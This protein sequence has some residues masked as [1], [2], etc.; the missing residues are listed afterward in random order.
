MS[1]EK[2]AFV[3]T[4]ENLEIIKRNRAIVAAMETRSV[5]CLC[6]QHKTIVLHQRTKEPIYV[7]QKCSKCK[8]E[9]PY[10]LADYRRG[11]SLK[12]LLNSNGYTTK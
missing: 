4:Q 9:A 1:R 8:F 7:S 6:C 3:P 2:T 11:I 12:T 5:P 10:N